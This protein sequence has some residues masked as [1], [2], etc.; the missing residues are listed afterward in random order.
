MRLHTNDTFWEALHRIIPNLPTKYV[1]KCVITVTAC[2]AVV[3]D[4]TMFALD[5]AGKPMRQEIDGEMGLAVETRR[6]RIVP[7]EEPAA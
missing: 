3:V 1:T 2:D 4:L 6:F 7:D 5:G